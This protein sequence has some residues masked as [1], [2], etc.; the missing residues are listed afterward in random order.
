M[1]NTMSL[2]ARSLARVSLAGLMLALAP[3]GAA[4]QAQ[5]PAA[6]VAVTDDAVLSALR[7][8]G[9][10]DLRAVEALLAQG[11]V[12]EGEQALLE[13][14]RASAHLRFNE[15]RRALARYF[16]LQDQNPERAYLGHEIAAGIALLAG[17]YAAAAR[18]AD[19]QLTLSEG[20]AEDDIQNLHR[21]RDIGRQLAA[22]PPQA[23]EAQGNGAAVP[24][25]RDKVGLL[26]SPI[27]VNGQVQD[28]VLDTGANVSVVSASAALRLGL[29]FM[30]GETSIGN[31]VGGGVGIRMAV[32]DRLEIGGAVVRNV[33]FA[34]MDD[35]ALD[36]PVP[37]GY[38]IDAILGLPVLRSIGRVEFNIGAKSLRVAPAPVASAQ[39]A[40]LRVIGNAPYAM[41]SIGGVE[42]PIYFDTGANSTSLYPPFAALAPA[43]QAVPDEKKTSQ[44][45]VGGVQ[46]IQNMFFQNVP[47]A[48]GQQS[49]TVARIDYRPGGSGDK[50]RPYGVLGI[51]VLSR[52]ES[53][54]IDY[55]NMVLE[56]GNPVVPQ[57]ASR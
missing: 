17:D 50:E 5:A 36:F 22:V 26:R 30:E 42:L 40:N 28:A 52:F 15:A 51:D 31:S 19:M 16:A 18:H 46:K 39:L 9:H 13:A 33:I 1:S 25:V 35:A 24:L 55:Q 38:K 47:V 34:V 53:F 12:Q 27:S 20:R 23:V 4:A 54:A 2:K 57:T 45:G 49:A 29:R 21:M 56:V 32:A 37:G 14:R 44:A 6:G 7:Q 10:G 41:M 43:L 11:G 3:L 8:A 48:I